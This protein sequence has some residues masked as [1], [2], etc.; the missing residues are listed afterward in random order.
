MKRPPLVAGAVSYFRGL[1]LVALTMRAMVLRAL[2]RFSGWRI[3]SFHD[4][5]MRMLNATVA[6]P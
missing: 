3:A 6:S 4:A 2:A 5:G 1:A